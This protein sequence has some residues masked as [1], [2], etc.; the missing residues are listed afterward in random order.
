MEGNT[1]ELEPIPLSMHSLQKRYDGEEGSRERH[2]TTDSL[3]VNS[4]LAVLIELFLRLCGI[5]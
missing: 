4:I 1:W 2:Y 3:E 5:M